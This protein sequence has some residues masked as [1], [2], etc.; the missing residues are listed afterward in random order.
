MTDAEGARGQFPRTVFLPGLPSF[1]TRL[2]L[3][4]VSVI[5]LLVGL[6][7]ASQVLTSR[8][9]V[10]RTITTIT[11]AHLD[12]DQALV[13]GY[14]DEAQRE[15]FAAEH[16]AQAG[17]LYPA[18]SAGVARLLMPMCDSTLQI[19]AAYLTDTAGNVL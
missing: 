19:S 9:L 3:A 8:R 4:L 16:W 18:D 12:H 6:M 7:L 15:L 17:L 10:R 1:R 5:L 13:G 2:T 11:G 14:F